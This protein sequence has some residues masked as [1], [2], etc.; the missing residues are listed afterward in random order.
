VID[1][2]ENHL[3]GNIPKELGA[4]SLLFLLKLNNNKLSGN[5]LEG[6]LPNNNAFSRAHIAGLEHNRDL[7]GDNTGLQACPFLLSKRPG[8]KMSLRA[9]IL[10]TVSLLGTLF[11]LYIIGG[12]YCV[13]FKGR[14]TDDE[15]RDVENE[16]MFA[17]WSYDGKIAHQ[18]SKHC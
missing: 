6:P 11:L 12:I 10:I 9:V 17:T 4:L 18:T 3:V 2:S 14:K 1:L 7:C 15:P 8:G 16:N 5:N 13:R